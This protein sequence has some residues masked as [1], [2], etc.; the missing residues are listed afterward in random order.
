VFELKERLVFKPAKVRQ[1][2]VL[3]ARKAFESELI[4]DFPVAI[5]A[6]VLR[7][8]LIT[9]MPCYMIMQDSCQKSIKI[10]ACKLLPVDTAT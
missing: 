2:G 9:V 7:V 10:I 3:A 8:A 6:C 5:I 1:F 4:A